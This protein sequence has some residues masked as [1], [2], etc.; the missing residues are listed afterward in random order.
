M[1]SGGTICACGTIDVGDVRRLRRGSEAPGV[2]GPL[3]DLVFF[4]GGVSSWP[5]VALGEGDVGAA[6]DIESLALG[7]LE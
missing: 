1:V 3:G 6:R 7:L 4:R 2:V 5:S